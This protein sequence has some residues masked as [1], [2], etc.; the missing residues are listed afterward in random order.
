MDEDRLGAERLNTRVSELAMAADGLKAELQTSMEAQGK[1]ASQHRQLH[2]AIKA[3]LVQEH[4]LAGR[5]E[6]N[7]CMSLV[8]MP[9]VP[10]AALKSRIIVQHDLAALVSHVS[11]DIAFLRMT[12][13]PEPQGISQHVD[14]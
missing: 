8:G 7:P 6:S 2:D 12:M 4:D 1:A 3:I 13:H 10:W 9:S 5:F 11:L 14:S